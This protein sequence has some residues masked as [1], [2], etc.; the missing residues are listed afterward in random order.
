MNSVALKERII[1]PIV[2]G[3]LRG[4]VKEHPTLLDGVLWFKPKT[5]KEDVFVNSAAKRII[6]DL[7]CDENIARLRS[8]LLESPSGGAD[9][10]EVVATNLQPPGTD[11]ES[12]LGP[13]LREGEGK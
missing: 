2:E 13:S 7:A 9:D 1:R 12:A 8:A 3:Q 6:N 5:N 11:L 10:A 4:M